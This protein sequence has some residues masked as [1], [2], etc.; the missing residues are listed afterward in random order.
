MSSDV[1]DPR[2]PSV[3]HRFRGVIPNP[4]SIIET[5]YGSLTRGG[6]T[7][8]D[9]GIHLGSGDRPHLGRLANLNLVGIECRHSR[10]K[11]EAQKA[12]KKKLPMFAKRTRAFRHCHRFAL[13]RGEGADLRLLYAGQISRVTSAYSARSESVRL[14]WIGIAASINLTGRLA[15]ACE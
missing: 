2:Y 6:S 8:S 14:G 15:F 1:S 12:R 11:R 10:G 3:G 4:C 9:P 7:R 5:P 13:N